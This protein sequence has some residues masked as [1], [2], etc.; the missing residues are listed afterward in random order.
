MDTVSISIQFG[1]LFTRRDN[2][3]IIIMFPLKLVDENAQ[4]QCINSI[5]TRFRYITIVKLR[6]LKLELSHGNNLL[7]VAVTGRKRTL[8][9]F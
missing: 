7:C 3:T 5:N 9:H 2:S 1:S 6:Q 4:V 8:F